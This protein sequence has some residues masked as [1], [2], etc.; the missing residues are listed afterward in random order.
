MLN[1]RTLSD[2]AQMPDPYMPDTEG[3][4]FVTDITDAN[5]KKY[6]NATISLTATYNISVYATKEG[7]NNSDVVTATLCWIDVEPKTEGITNNVANVRA[8]PVMIQTNGST[9]TVSGADDGTSISV[10]SMAH[11]QAQP[12]WCSYNLHHPAIR[13]TSHHKGWQ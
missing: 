11:K 13:L 6:Y 3:V 1:I 9:L 10:Y 12:E 8:L 4:T 7:Y 5:I 2:G